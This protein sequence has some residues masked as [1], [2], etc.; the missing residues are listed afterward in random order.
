METT[1]KSSQARAGWVLGILTL[2]A[3]FVMG[4]GSSARPTTTLES[5]PQPTLIATPEVAPTRTATMTPTLEP[6]PDVAPTRTATMPPTLEPTHQSAPQPTPAAT[7]NRPEPEPSP[8]PAP[9]STPAFVGQR[10]AGEYEGITFLVVEGSKATFTV[11]EQLVRLPIP[12]DAVMR[13]SAL[14]GEVHLD[15]GPSVIE[16]DLRQL[17]SDQALRDGYVR[18]RMFGTH[19]T[20]VFTLGDVRLLPEGFADGEEITTQLTGQ[21]EIVGIE[22][23]LKFDIEA[24]DDGDVI[25]I[26]GRT[27]FVWADFRMTAPAARPVVSVEDEVKV[28]LLLAVRP[29]L[30]PDG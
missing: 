24:R 27:S 15:G 3:L 10:E 2:L 21:I 16:I 23:P 8:S 7:P 13:T 29:V 19:P 26:V 18:R 1:I 14:S 9:T 5:A 25:F 6:T 4:C 12:S 17:R 30:T 11:R 28:E 20:A 22:A